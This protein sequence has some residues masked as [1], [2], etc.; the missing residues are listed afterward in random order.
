M[1]LQRN[2]GLQQQ[3]A[4]LPEDGPAVNHG[5]LHSPSITPS[6]KPRRAWIEFLLKHV[7]FNSHTRQSTQSLLHLAAARGDPDLVNWILAQPDVDANIVMTKDDEGLTALFI[8]C[9]EGHAAVVDVLLGRSDI[10]VNKATTKSSDTPL[11][12]AWANGHF[13]TVNRLL[14]YSGLNVNS[15]D[16]DGLTPLCRASGEGRL[17]VVNQLLS[18]RDIDVNDSGGDGGSGLTPLC[19]ASEEGHHDVVDR[20]LSHY[21]IDVNKAETLSPGRTPLLIAT[22][23]GHLAVVERLL[24]PPAILLDESLDESSGALLLDESSGQYFIFDKATDQSVWF[25]TASGSEVYRDDVTGLRYAHNAATDVTVWLEAAFECIDVNKGTTIDDG[26]TALFRAVL[27]GH[28]EIVEQLL[29]HPNIDVNKARMRM[30]RRPVLPGDKCHVRS[31]DSFFRAT[32]QSRN[33]DSWSYEVT[34]DNGGRESNV[35]LKTRIRNTPWSNES[36]TDSQALYLPGITPLVA[37]IHQRHHFIAF[38]LLAHPDI[39]V[40]DDGRQC[41]YSTPVREPGRL[42]RDHRSAVVWLRR[43]ELCG[44]N[45]RP[46]RL[47]CRECERPLRCR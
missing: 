19:R 15:A 24:R 27:N 10:D 22:D 44:N 11:R 43:C 12:I 36:Y 3:P 6:I 14:L 38:Q 7:D 23:K 2:T 26:D 46:N 35:D 18:R 9:R 32:L 21:C 28:S 40:N 34:Y 25:R 1:L 37:A 8:A 16:R 39:D 20:L 4:E 41:R 31:G 30:V 33:A 5:L 29:S 42:L 13:D 17:N 47:G 45:V